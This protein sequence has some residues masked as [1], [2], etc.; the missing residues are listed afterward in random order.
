MHSAGCVVILFVAGMMQLTPLYGDEG[1]DLSRHLAAESVTLLKNE[2]N[3]LPLGRD[4][5]KLAVIGPHANSTMIGFPHYTYPAVLNMLRIA[6]KLRVCPA[7][8]L[9]AN[10]PWSMFDV[11]G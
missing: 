1:D 10:W 6:G 4:I 8:M 5:K 11:A 7:L 3:L 2:K 9:L